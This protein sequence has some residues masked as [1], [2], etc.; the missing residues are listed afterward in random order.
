MKNKFVMFTL[1]YWLNSRQANKSHR[2]H[3]KQ[4]NVTNLFFHFLQSIR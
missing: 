4:Q 2:V 3:N 1:E